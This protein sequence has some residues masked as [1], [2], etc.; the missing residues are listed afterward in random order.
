M[1]VRTDQSPRGEQGDRR[2][3]RPWRQ[4]LSASLPVALARCAHP[5]QALAITL[6]LG[7]AAAVAGRSTREVGLVL[8]TVLVGQVLL[9]WH[10]DIVDTERDRRHSRPDKPIALGQVERGTVSY[11][12]A[13]GVLVVVPLSIANGVV[14]GLTHVGV[15]LVAMAGNAGLLRRS[16]FSYLPWMAT[17][18]LLPAFL[19][20]GGFA[21]EGSGGPP[22]IAMTAL[23]ALLGI[24]VHVT[25]ALPG[26]V[27]DDRDGI[28]SFPLRVALRTGAPR[29]LVIATAYN[30]A[31]GA[32]ILV[33]AR[34]VGL[35]Q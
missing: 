2:P 26:L 5:R 35:V 14:A 30:L 25:R 15:L 31:V 16:R 27:D 1:S 6:A 23:A 3:A 32:G 29:L 20:Y 17:F 33:A 8:A 11:A 21:G 22:T 18:G 19:S 28:R 13:C 12:L 24:G 7:V 10:N 4:R 9:G 34:A